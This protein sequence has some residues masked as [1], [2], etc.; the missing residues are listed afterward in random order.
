MTHDS[1]SIQ[2]MLER[3]QRAV[4]K[5]ERAASAPTEPPSVLAKRAL[6]ARERAKAEATGP[7]A[8]P[9]DGEV[10]G[11]AEAETDAEQGA[12]SRYF[13][14]QSGAWHKLMDRETGEQVGKS[15]RSEAEAW[16]LLEGD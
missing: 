7:E 9:V 13:V 6:R 12:E 3:R 14:E 16:A 11:A 10:E 5:R 4:D 2:A 1:T 15:Q 8:E